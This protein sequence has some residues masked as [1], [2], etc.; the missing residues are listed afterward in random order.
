[1]A[2]CALACLIGI[3]SMSRGDSNYDSE[4]TG[5]VVRHELNYRNRQNAIGIDVTHESGR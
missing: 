5:I 1:M 4:T 2:T 3:A